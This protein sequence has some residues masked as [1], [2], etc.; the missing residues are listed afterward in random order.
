MYRHFLA[1]GRNMAIINPD[2]E[3]DRAIESVS[4]GRPFWKKGKKQPAETF[5]TYP[6]KRAPFF[7]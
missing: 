5:R 2:D 1:L 7:I 4:P 3:F 6:E